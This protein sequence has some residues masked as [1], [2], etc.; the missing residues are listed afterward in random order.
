MANDL[1]P[2]VDD[3]TWRAELEELRKREKAERK[4]GEGDE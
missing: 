4:S 3:K 1:P 2:V